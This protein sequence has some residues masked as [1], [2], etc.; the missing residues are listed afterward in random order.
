MF[1]AFQ[2]TDSKIETDVKKELHWDPSL[3]A[4]DISLSVTDGIVTLRGTVPHYFEKISA[5]AAAQRIGGV[6]G[7]ANEIEVRLHSDFVRRDEDIIE[8]ARIALDWGYLVPKGVTVMAEQGW[9]T[10]GGGCCMGI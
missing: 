3:T 8:A 9:L 6:R 7:V 5:A 4:Q 10:L 2:K 1:I